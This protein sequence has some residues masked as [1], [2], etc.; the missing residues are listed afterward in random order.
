MSERGLEAEAI[1][2]A[3]KILEVTFRV[4][5]ISRDLEIA[6]E[7]VRSDE[8]KRRKTLKQ[9]R[10]LSTVSVSPERE[11]AMKRLY[12]ELDLKVREQGLKEMTTLKF[13]EAAGLTDLY[14][15][16]YAHYSGSVHA[17]VRDLE[18]A[19]SLDEDG[20]V[21]GFVCGP[22]IEFQTRVLASAVEMVLLS[23]DAASH[24]YDDSTSGI[25]QL[26]RKLRHLFGSF[27][28]GA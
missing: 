21:D 6:W 1:L 27:S 15:S 13:A 11:Q 19:L 7:Y 4:V 20:E 8:F 17:N 12:A 9:L 26:Q 10:S 18:T 14:N 23:L 5:A 3:R 24:L 22:R 16:A 25:R 2:L 28:G